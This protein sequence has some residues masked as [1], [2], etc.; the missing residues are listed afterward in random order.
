M[1]LF[2]AFILFVY[3]VIADFLSLYNKVYGCIVSF[4]SNFFENILFLIKFYIKFA[5]I[6]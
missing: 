5:S 1:F 4:L 6:T 2:I 3:V